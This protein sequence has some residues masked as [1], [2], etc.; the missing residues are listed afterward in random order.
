MKQILYIDTEL[1]ALNE[2]IGAN[3]TN[4][5][6]GAN[7]KRKYTNLVAWECKHQGVKPF[8]KKIDIQFTW[9][10]KNKRK[11]KDNIMASQKFVFDGLQ[12]AGVIQNDGWKEIGNIDHRFK[13]DKYNV[14]VEVFMKECEE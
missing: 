9:N 2:I 12:L 5:F 4:K 10:C 1:P 7:L 13:V 11:D 14:G 8:N 6:S 3:R